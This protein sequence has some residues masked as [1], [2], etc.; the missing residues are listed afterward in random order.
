MLFLDTRFGVKHS[1]TGQ[2]HCDLCGAIIGKS[3]ELPYGLKQKQLEKSYKGHEAAMKKA[4]KKHGADGVEKILPPKLAKMYL[5]QVMANSRSQARKKNTSSLVRH[6]TTL[7]TDDPRS[8]AMIERALSKKTTEPSSGIDEVINI[9]GYGHYVMQVDIDGYLSHEHLATGDYVGSKLYP[10][11]ELT[12]IPLADGAHLIFTATT[13]F[14]TDTNSDFVLEGLAEFSEEEE[15][16][17]SYTVNDEGF[18]LYVGG[19]RVGKIVFDFDKFSEWTVEGESTIQ[20][21]AMWL[22]LFDKDPLMELMA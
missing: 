18:E 20:G 9:P 14:E 1:H 15:F 22:I 7:H 17:E 11:L 21:S 2:F 3:N 5:T 13:A 6:F 4:W 19:S 10:L 12:L 8:K 16:F